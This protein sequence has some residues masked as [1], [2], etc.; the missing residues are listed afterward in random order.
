MNGRTAR[1]PALATGHTVVV[2]PPSVTR[3]TAL[4]LGELALEAGFAPGVVNVT[5]LPGGRQESLAR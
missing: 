1:A 4:L 3:V 5:T 2:K